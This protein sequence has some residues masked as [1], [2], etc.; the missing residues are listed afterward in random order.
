MDKQVDIHQSLE[1]FK[2]VNHFDRHMGLELKI[3]GEKVLYQLEIQEKHL[4]SPDAGHGGV[5]AAMMDA[6]LGVTSLYRAL[7]KNK[8]CSTVEMKTNFLNPV[9]LGDILIGEG[10]I[11]FEGQS[12]I[13]TSACL[14]LK[15]DKMIA[16]GIGTFNLYPLS[17]K[18]MES[19]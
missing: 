15:N 12:L 17:K 11:D 6:T 16:K 7:K 9:K 19:W 1:L 8:L 18:G 3:E 5:I 14:K 4:S 10:V 13:V 2:K